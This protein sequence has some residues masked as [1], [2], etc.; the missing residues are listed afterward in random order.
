MGVVVA[1]FAA[2]TC[3]CGEVV[4]GIS[5]GYNV[6]G[7]IVCGLDRLFG[8]GCDQYLSIWAGCENS[9]YSRL[10]PPRNSRGGVL[11]RP[12]LLI[13][14]CSLLLAVRAGEW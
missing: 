10:F 9:G 11:V 8:R 3:V 5:R 6:V 4:L 14:Y 12:R 13:V 1:F 2:C 7:M